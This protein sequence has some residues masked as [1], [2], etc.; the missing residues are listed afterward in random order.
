MKQSVH[1]LIVGR[2]SGP[3]PSFAAIVMRCLL[4]ELLHRLIFIRAV[5]GV[6]LRVGA[7]EQIA[8]VQMSPRLLGRR[9]ICKTKRVE[10]TLVRAADCPS[11]SDASHGRRSI[12]PV[13]TLFAGYE[14]PYTHEEE[15]D[16][17]SDNMDNSTQD[18]R[19]VYMEQITGRFVY[20]FE[21]PS[22]SKRG[23]IKHTFIQ[24]GETGLA[25]RGLP[26]II[27]DGTKA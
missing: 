1:L 9:L 16:E 2:G 23:R 26:L 20:E 5:L 24:N 4:M 7:A 3:S 22:I 18:A 21:S 25:G 12:A 11:A 14:G 17:S 10:R 6:Q 27:P 15:P 19:A 13:S 8:G